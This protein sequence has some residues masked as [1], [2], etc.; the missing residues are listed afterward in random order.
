MLNCSGNANRAELSSAVPLWTMPSRTTQWKSAINVFIYSVEDVG[1]R[2]VCPIKTLAPS[3][4]IGF[5]TCLS[6]Y[7]LAYL[8]A[9]RIRHQR[10]HAHCADRARMADK[11]DLPFWYCS[12]FTNCTIK[13]SHRWMTHDVVQ[14]SPVVQFPIPIQF[15]CCYL[16]CTGNDSVNTGSSGPGRE[17]R[18]S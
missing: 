9:D 10:V 15:N 8:C 12:T 18:A 4:L 11:L 2:N 7:V 5:P 13:F 1:P 14:R 17:R 16:F 6:T 3:V